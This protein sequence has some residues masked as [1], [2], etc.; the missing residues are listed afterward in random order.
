MYPSYPKGVMCEKCKT[1][2]SLLLQ[3]ESVPL[4]E[5]FKSRF[6]EACS[7]KMSNYTYCKNNPLTNSKYPFSSIKKPNMQI[8]IHLSRSMFIT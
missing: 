8:E 1:Y 5:D 2:T 3:N 4:V 7:V 6:N